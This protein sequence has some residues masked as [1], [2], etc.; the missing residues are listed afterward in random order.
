LHPTTAHAR[1]AFEA[2]R[3][4]LRANAWDDDDH[5]QAIAARYDLGAHV[6]TF[7]QFGGAV[8]TDI[9]DH[10][11]E[12]NRDENLPR[13]YPYDGRGHRVDRV[14]LHEATHAIGRIVWPTGIMA[15]Y[16]EVG[17]ERESLTLLY[18]L[19]QNGEAGHCCPLACTAGLIRI[20]QVEAHEDGRTDANWVALRQAWLERLLSTDYADRWHGAQFLTE[21]QGGSDVGA[22]VV[23]ATPAED[24]SYRLHGEKWFCSVADAPLYLVS[25]RPDDGRDGTRGVMAF[26]VARHLPD[27]APNALRLRRLK[28]KLGTRSMA[29]AEIDFEGAIGWP[30]GDFRR[31][32]E[33]VLDRSRLYNAVCNCGMMQRA[34]REA[35]RYAYHRRAF[36]SRVA[37]FPA[38]ARMLADLRVAACAA[39]GLTFRLAALSDAIDLAQAGD[40]DRAAAR[41]LTNLNKYWTSHLAT[42]QLRAA[43]EVLGGNGAIEDF[44]VLPR[45]LRDSVVTEAWEGG[46]NVLC[47]QA[48]RDASRLRLHEPMFGFLTALA[49]TD[50]VKRRLDGEAARWRWLADQPAEVG[51]LH[52]RDAADRL[53][54]VA[55]AAA[56]EAE[57]DDGPAGGAAIVAHLLAGDPWEDRGLADRIRQI[58]QAA[59]PAER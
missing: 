56:I 40:T 44:S 29:S 3:A 52:I 35:S 59:L 26:V 43:I 54:V 19:A 32:V 27:G 10:A 6:A 13:W 57:G 50:G 28:S 11:V 45:L 51:A 49:R 1:Q 16:R 4:A 31:I 20:L 34:W 30:V 22:N 58:N 41:I 14:A 47:A 37:D 25:A 23:R 7:R 5:I 46:H 39:R 21:V 42:S 18:L 36:G 38:V 48:L 8:S 15:R 2:W 12:A 9:D 53:R 24:G 33:V 17:H 55:Q